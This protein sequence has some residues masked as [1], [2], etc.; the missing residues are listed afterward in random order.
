MKATNDHYSSPLS[1]HLPP[2]HSDSHA[3]ARIP[4]PSLPLMPSLL[5][6]LPQAYKLASINL[7]PN[8]PGQ[9]AM[10]VMCAPPKPGEPS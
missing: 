4:L 3:C 6:T 7:S 1:P 9:V 5:V 8:V 10:G 2:S